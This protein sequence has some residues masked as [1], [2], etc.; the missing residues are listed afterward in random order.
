MKDR[1]QKAKRKSDFRNPK[2]QSEMSDLERDLNSSL[3]VFEQM[4]QS[5]D[6]KINV[7]Q[8][9]NDKLKEANAQL[10]GRIKHLEEENAQMMVR[11]KHVED[12][13]EI[14]QLGQL[15]TV[16]ERNVSK[17]LLSPEVKVGDFGGLTFMIRYLETEEDKEWRPRQ[18]KMS[19]KKKGGVSTRCKER[20]MGKV[21]KIESYHVRERNPVRCDQWN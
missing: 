7:L 11:L 9:D 1:I 18:M 13:I 4:F 19:K 17:F 14:V 3:N 12:E 20:G 10:M 5:L 21:Q 16:F 2:I 8:G 15:M 6:N